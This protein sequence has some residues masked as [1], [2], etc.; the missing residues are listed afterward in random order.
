MTQLQPGHQPYKETL[1]QLNICCQDNPLPIK[2][3]S[4]HNSL[5]DGGH[6]YGVAVR[7][8]RDGNVLP[9]ADAMGTSFP[10][11]LAICGR[12]HH[13]GVL[14]VP[15]G[16]EGQVAGVDVLVHAGDGGACL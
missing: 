5:V 12:G 11:S 9:L 7:V 15:I 10:P 8:G 13:L 4:T 3:S 2:P 6:L 1:Y 16:G 14:T